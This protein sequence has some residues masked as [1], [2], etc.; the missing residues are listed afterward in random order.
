VA[1]PFPPRLD[2][3][4]GGSRAV[5]QL[6]AALAVRHRVALLV[7]KSQSEPGVDDALRGVCDLVDEVEIPP[8]GRSIGDRLIDR[9]RLRAGLLRGI[10]TWAAQR[11]A[12]D[13]GQRFAR[14]VH[15]WRPD[16][17]QLEYRIMG[18]FLPALSACP[19]PRILVDPDPVSVQ[20]NRFGLLGPLEARAWRSLGR[21]VFRQVDSLVVLTERDREMLSELSG[22]TPIARV[23]LAYD[24]PEAPLD[25]A[26]R[27]HYG[28]V[29]VGSFIH[30]PNI[31]ASAWLA[32]EIFPSVKARIPAA[33]LQ[34]V[35]SQAPGGKLEIGGE[36]VAVRLDVP[37]V[38]PYLD[39]AAVVA[40]PIRLGGGMRVKVLEAL[41]SGKA[42]VATPLALEGLDVRDGEHVV[43]AETAAEFADA[44]VGLLSDAE[45]RTAIATGARLWAEQH[46]SME[47]QVRAYETLFASL[48]GG[49]SAF[50]IAAGRPDR[51]VR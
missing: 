20:G 43:V 7:L 39:A 31:D 10:P 12:P 15:D 27:D 11:T 44:L 33:S 21:S 38:R 26:G 23:P 4:H 17:V 14:L 18:G 16:I 50:A 40:A 13:F 51:L 30:P 9:I 19:A 1:A 8:V 22:S 3:R 5:A 35:G 48:I 25:P 29:C 42:I 6:V 36:G 2:G 28:I 49:R 34:V 45:R 37:D 47:S 46:L 24:I 32:G 41:A